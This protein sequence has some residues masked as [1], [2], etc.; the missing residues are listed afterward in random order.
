[1]QQ[2][3]PNLYLVFVRKPETDGKLNYH[4]ATEYNPALQHF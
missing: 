1:M 3:N 4:P 2:F